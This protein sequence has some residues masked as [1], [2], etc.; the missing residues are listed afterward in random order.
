VSIQLLKDFFHLS[1]EANDSVYYSLAHSVN[2]FFSNSTSLAQMLKEADIRFATAKGRTAPLLELLDTAGNTKPLYNK[3]EFT[4]IDFW[5]SWCVPCRKE[6]SS[7]KKVFDKYHPAGFTITSISLDSKKLLWK[8]AIR[9]DKMIWL[10]LSDLKGW[11]GMPPQVYGVKAIPMNFLVDKEGSIV[12]KN[13][14]ADQLDK[15]LNSLLNRQ[16]F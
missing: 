5:A 10:Q 11:D 7:L 4:L 9:Q 15:L 6:N 8:N 16:A 12:A 14:S 2:S 13:L 1:T 3:G